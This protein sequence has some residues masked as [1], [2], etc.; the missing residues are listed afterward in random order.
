MIAMRRDACRLSLRCIRRVRA[1]GL[2][3]TAVSL[4]LA[5]CAGLL[6]LGKF[7]DPGRVVVL[8]T[9][10]AGTPVKGVFCALNTPDLLLVWRSG[11][12]GGTGQVEIGQS[13]GG[14]LPGDYVLIVKPPNGYSLAPG[15]AN[16]VPVE[17]RSRETS[18]T[19]VV[20]VRQ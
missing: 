3:V 17:V 11:V 4:S 6:D 2:F 15:Q 19:T 1:G 18:R 7:P 16:N 14:V 5:G 10:P 8:T 20:L 12:T 9:S 13:D